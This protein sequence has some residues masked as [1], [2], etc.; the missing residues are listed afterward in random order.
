MPGHAGSPVSVQSDNWG[1][2]AGHKGSAIPY[3]AFIETVII[4]VKH[5][6]IPAGGLPF[7]VTLFTVSY[8]PGAIVKIDFLFRSAFLFHPL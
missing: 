8:L 3:G 6:S 4:G 2:T 5:Q 1:I 7:L